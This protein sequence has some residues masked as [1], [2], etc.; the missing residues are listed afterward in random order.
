[1]I[2][3]VCYIYIK[4]S[5]NSNPKWWAELTGCAAWWKSDTSNCRTRAPRDDQKVVP[6]RP[7][8]RVFLSRPVPLCSYLRV[9]SRPVSR[10]FLSRPASPVPLILSCEHSSFSRS[11]IEK[12]PANLYFLLQYKSFIL[13]FICFTI[14]FT[15][16]YFYH[17]K[18]D[19]HNK[20]YKFK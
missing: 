6:S 11:I 18:N 19:K 3:V 7:M 12:N 14:L 2:A 17:K 13:L 20:K 5:V 10:A 9:P 4:L 8:S 1:M 16:Q 15:R